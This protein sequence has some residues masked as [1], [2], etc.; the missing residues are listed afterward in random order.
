M[1]DGRL[2]EEIPDEMVKVVVNSFSQNRQTGEKYRV[3]ISR[4]ENI[5]AEETWNRPNDGKKKS[6]L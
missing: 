6:G 1:N 2:I 4:G 5:A 3:P